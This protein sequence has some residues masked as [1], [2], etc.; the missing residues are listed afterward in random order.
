MAMPDHHKTR[1]VEN[2]WSYL[3][4]QLLLSI[5]AFKGF[6]SGR[7]YNISGNKNVWNF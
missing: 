6:V 2:I 7:S 5:T 3:M 1:S 4:D